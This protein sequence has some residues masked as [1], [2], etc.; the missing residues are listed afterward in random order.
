MVMVVIYEDDKIILMMG[1]ISIIVMRIMIMMI[2]VTIITID[3]TI[4]V[5]L[6][7]TVNTYYPFYVEMKMTSEHY[8]CN[9]QEEINHAKPWSIICKN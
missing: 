9:H 6:M 8:L 3:V 5:M 4:G 2:G 7:G 1:I